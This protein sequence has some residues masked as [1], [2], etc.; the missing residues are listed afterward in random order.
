MMMHEGQTHIKR[1]CFSIG[2]ISSNLQSGCYS[3]PSFPVVDRGAT[4]GFRGGVP[5]AS[6]VAAVTRAGVWDR[7]P[8]AAGV[9]VVGRFGE[10][11]HGGRAGLSTLEARF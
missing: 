9:C 7:V 1:N 3:H 6:S 8:G 5:T 10:H 4:T 2:I 11:G